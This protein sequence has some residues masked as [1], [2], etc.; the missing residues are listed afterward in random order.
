MPLLEDRTGI[1]AT[2]PM[3]THDVTNATSKLQVSAEA[4]SFADGAAGT[5]QRIKLTYDGV[6]DANGERIGV[7]G[8]T[9]FAFITGTVLT[10]QVPWRFKNTEGKDTETD[11][12]AS[13]D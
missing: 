3:P 9:S 4:V 10:T 5:T 1:K 7:D 8:N 11:R 6:M 13:I 2:T 12:L